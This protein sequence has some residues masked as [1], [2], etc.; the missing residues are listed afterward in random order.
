MLPPAHELRRIA[1]M[2]VDEMERIAAERQAHGVQPIPYDELLSTARDV[3]FLREIV[4]ADLDLISFR[5][6]V[7][8]LYTD[9]WWNSACV[10]P[11]FT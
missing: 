10:A 4:P 3:V 1:V 7:A 5:Y 8:I 2:T 6:Q 11:L 9:R